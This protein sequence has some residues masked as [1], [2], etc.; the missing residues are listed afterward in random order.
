MAS[1]NITKAVVLLAAP[2]MLAACGG[3]AGGP[4]GPSFLGFSSMN[5][6][7]TTTINGIGKEVSVDTKPGIEN[8]TAVS[9]FTATGKTSVD[10]TLDGKE[11]ITAVA[12]KTPTT[13][14]KWDAS[15]S[16]LI[17]ND[18][19]L[20]AERNDGR[21]YAVAASPEALGFEYQTF[22]VWATS[23]AEE[24]K[25]KIGVF[26]VGAESKAS[27]LPSAGTAAFK[28]AA[29]GIY[30]DKTGL[31]DIVTAEAT[32]GADFAARKVSF[33]TTQTES[34]L[35]GSRSDLNL[36]GNLSYAAGS[37]EL[38]GTVATAGGSMTG[39]ADG[40]FYG[41]GAQ[42]VGG[43]FALKGKAPGSL[44]SFGGGFGAVKK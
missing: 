3:G 15:N 38:T 23:N 10:I 20:L 39:N 24:T 36:I 40:R 37:N 32:L 26:S 28:G 12:I 8:A 34:L 43:I 35:A 1:R 27:A 21:S 14:E 30:T 5:A 22:G 33:A 42:E 17:E 13:S 2:L 7:G 9:A 25:G 44:E 4:G 31:A 29:G 16:N 19:L 41:P 11:D 18:G 6:P